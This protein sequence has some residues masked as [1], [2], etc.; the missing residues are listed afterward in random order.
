M[1]TFKTERP[2]V[3]RYL[4]KRLLITLFILALPVLYEKLFPTAFIRDTYYSIAPVL[5]LI[6]MIDEMSKVFLLELKFDDEKKEITFLY[7]T[8]FSSQK[9]KKLSFE[10]A[11]VEMVKSKFKQKWLW[12]PLTLYFYKNKKEVFEVKGSKDGF[13]IETLKSICKIAENIPLPVS[14][15]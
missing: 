13:S 8:V 5:F 12:E 15:V 6:R 2:N 9:H 11:K 10:N 3:F 14:K 1:I 4:I 7:K